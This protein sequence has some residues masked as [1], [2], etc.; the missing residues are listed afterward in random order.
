MLFHYYKYSFNSKSEMAYQL[1]QTKDN[2][3]VM[4][5]FACY[6]WRCVLSVHILVLTLGFVDL[7]AR[8]M[9]QCV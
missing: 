1:F 2:T 9:L 8:I 3:F 7:R 4:L 6:T 5:V